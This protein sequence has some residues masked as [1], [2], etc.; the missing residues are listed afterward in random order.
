MGAVYRSIEPAVLDGDVFTSVIPLGPPDQLLH[1]KL[2]CGL[3]YYVR[4]CSKPRQR[5]AL[6]L[7]VKVGSLV[8]DEAERGV[9]HILE[10]LA[11]N[12]T[13]V[14]VCVSRLMTSSHCCLGGSSGSSGSSR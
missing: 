4:R 10:H 14:C 1:G 11:F 7:A 12:A 8:E 5:A 3:T 13:E 6:A 2:E 9:A